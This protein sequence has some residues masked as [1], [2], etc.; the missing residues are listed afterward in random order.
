MTNEVLQFIKNFKFAHKEQL[1]HIFMSGNCYYFAVILKD[2]FNGQIY[3]LPNKNHFI[4]KINNEYYD[5][6][7][8]A[9]MNET[10][11]EWNTFIHK[12]PKEYIK[13]KRNCID[14]VTRNKQKGH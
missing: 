14:F 4:C 5:I 7:G 1:E 13:I 11:I 2:K 9:S 10:P 8:N 3:Y 6:T 12:Y